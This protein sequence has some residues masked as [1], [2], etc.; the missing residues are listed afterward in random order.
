MLRWKRSK[1]YTSR[2]GASKVTEIHAPLAW[3][4]MVIGLILVSLWVFLSLLCLSAV[5]SVAIYAVESGLGWNASASAARCLILLVSV[6]HCQCFR[7]NV[8]D[9]DLALSVLLQCLYSAYGSYSRVS[10]KFFFLI[11]Y[12]FL[13]NILG[14]RV[15]YQLARE[16]VWQLAS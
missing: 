8:A 1:K 12:G 10:V 4:L 5:S 7:L 3:N 9:E 13:Y 2:V 14:V 16:L 6:R 15:R 11:A